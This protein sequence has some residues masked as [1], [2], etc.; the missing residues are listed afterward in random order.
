MRIDFKQSK[1][2]Q[3]YSFVTPLCCRQRWTQKQ[4]SKTSTTQWSTRRRI[5]TT[6]WEINMTLWHKRLHQ[7]LVEQGVVHSW[8]LWDGAKFFGSFIMPDSVFHD[9]CDSCDYYIKVFLRYCLC[10]PHYVIM[11]KVLLYYPW[12]VF[13]CW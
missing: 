6:P 13:L 7:Q 12:I 3:I 10:K 8:F 5:R 9:T 1:A 11:M 2:K 4:R